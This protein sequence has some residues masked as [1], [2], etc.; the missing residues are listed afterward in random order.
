LQS[1]TKRKLFVSSLLQNCIIISA[2]VNEVNIGGDEA[3]G[4]SV[5][6]SVYTMTH[7]LHVSY[8]TGRNG[9]ALL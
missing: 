3:I 9:V 1:F 4:R 8:T 2:R 7:H 5:R 6:S